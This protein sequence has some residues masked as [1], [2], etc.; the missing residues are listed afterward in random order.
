MNEPT[1]KE[2]ALR[3]LDQLQS[4]FNITKRDINESFNKRIENNRT[5]NTKIRLIS[6]DEAIFKVIIPWN[7]DKLWD[8]KKENYPSNAFHN[9][10]WFILRSEYIRLH[11][12]KTKINRLATMRYLSNRGSTING[13]I[14][15]YSYRYSNSMAYS[16]SYQDNHT[17][18]TEIRIYTEI[19]RSYNYNG[20]DSNSYIYYPKKNGICLD[21]NGAVKNYGSAYQGFFPVISYSL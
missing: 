20:N 17:N 3:L 21:K 2:E 7:A 13:F 15:E 8:N 19:G 14:S 9:N 12:T 1:T 11:G 5:P 18:E 10:K 16:V 4:K 6:V